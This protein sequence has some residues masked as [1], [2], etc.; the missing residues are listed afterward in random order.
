MS[1]NESEYDV[2]LDENGVAVNWELYEPC[3]ECGTM[4][5]REASKTFLSTSIDEDGH[6]NH[7][8]VLHIGEA[9]VVVCDNCELTLLDR[10]KEEAGR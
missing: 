4:H 10:P 8:D 3:P 7:A 9:M 1:D 6:V 2:E 5:F